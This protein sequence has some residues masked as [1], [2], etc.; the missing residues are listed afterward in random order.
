[1][2]VRIL[3]VT[4]VAVVLWAMFAR[5]SGAGG[6]EQRYVV[7]PA[8]T[9]WSIAASTYAGDPRQGVWQLQRRNHLHGTTI[10]PGQVLVLP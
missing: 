2:F 8:D 6:P 5:S 1:M 7:Q 10:A 9:L 4:L 3:L